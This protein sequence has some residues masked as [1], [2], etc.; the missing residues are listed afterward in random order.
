[1]ACI[2][3]Q[4]GAYDKWH[5]ICGEKA[6]LFDWDQFVAV[7]SKEISNLSLPS[8]DDTTPELVAEKS[9]RWHQLKDAISYKPAWLKSYLNKL[10]VKAK[11]RKRLLD[12][13]MA[14]H[15]HQVSPLLPAQYRDEWRESKAGLKAAYP[16]YFSYPNRNNLPIEKLKEMKDTLI[17]MKADLEE[18]GIKQFLSDDFKERAAAHGDLTHAWHKAQNAFKAHPL[19]EH[20]KWDDFDQEVE[21][22][23]ELE[24]EL[25]SPDFTGGLEAR[26]I[27]RHKHLWDKVAKAL[28]CDAKW[29]QRLLADIEDRV[30][31][32][33]EADER[34]E[35][36]R[37]A[38]KAMGDAKASFH[39]HQDALGLESVSWQQFEERATL[40][41]KRSWAET[42]FQPVVSP[43]G[44]S[45]H[46]AAK[47]SY[48]GIALGEIEEAHCSTCPRLGKDIRGGDT[49]QKSSIPRTYTDA[50]Q[51]SSGI[52]R[53]FT[54]PHGLLGRFQ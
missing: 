29:V 34:V 16:L 21:F 31:R 30:K 4:N 20:M 23:L 37:A 3:A 11:P 24:E 18:N 28:E 53:A 50:K 2:R 47:L 1:M 38:T 19:A 25:L 12:E 52:S 26:D 9:R 22:Y 17:Q 48:V 45:E 14:L 49:S 35:A 54:T 15:I 42:L 6:I 41:F 39:E 43:E 51:G 33:E 7:A 36:S 46:S 10:E 40:E 44:Q 8:E 13:I 5:G 32:V 27:R